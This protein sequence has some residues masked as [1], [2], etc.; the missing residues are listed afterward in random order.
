MTR[1][2]T[3]ELAK[4]QTELGPG[5]LPPSLAEKYHCL[6]NGPLCPSR[7]WRTP[8][9]PLVGFDNVTA[10]GDHM[11]ENDVMKVESAVS[12][13]QDSPAYLAR[14]RGK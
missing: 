2:T 6:I 3:E 11:R 9:S 5:F 1:N 8:I 7:C 12:Y 10:M 4:A 13:L 14:R